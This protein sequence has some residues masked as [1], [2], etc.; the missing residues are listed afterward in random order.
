[1]GSPPPPTRGGGETA[2]PP[3][4][5]RP[6]PP[7]DPTQ[8]PPDPPHPHSV[9]N[10][11]PPLPKWERDRS[12]LP[13][14]A[15]RQVL[16]EDPLVIFG[17][18]RPF[19]LVALVEEGE[20]EGEADVVEDER[21]LSPADHRPRAHHGRDVAVDEALAR[22]VRDLDHALD[23]LAAAL[24]VVLAGLGEHDPRPGLGRQ[25]TERPD[26]GA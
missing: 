3:P 24:M 19:G 21:V 15:F 7:A 26:D 11:S 25:V 1:M 23:L 18:Q 4:L 16:A 2:L 5:S 9:R 17:D 6:P 10:G 12:R 20:A 8:P 22:Q 14:Y 13:H